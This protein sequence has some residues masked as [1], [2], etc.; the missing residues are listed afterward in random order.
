M[1]AILVAQAGNLETG[2]AAGSLIF[3]NPLVF[4]DSKL[5]NLRAFD[6][7]GHIF[8]FHRAGCNEHNFASRTE[9]YRCNAPRDLSSSKASR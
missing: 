4:R 1:A 6:E 2:F 3:F 8:E 7:Y 5:E 9:C